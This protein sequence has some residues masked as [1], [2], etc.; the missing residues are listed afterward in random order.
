[1][2]KQ[3]VTDIDGFKP[4]VA[5]NEKGHAAVR[6]FEIQQPHFLVSAK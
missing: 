1:M 3:F 5:T 4:R 6:V 2:G